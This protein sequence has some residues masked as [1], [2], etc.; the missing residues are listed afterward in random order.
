MYI[1]TYTWDKLRQY[2]EQGVQP[3]QPFTETPNNCFPTNLIPRPAS[4]NLI[5]EILF[6]ENRSLGSP[7]ATAMGGKVSNTLHLQNVPNRPYMKNLRNLRIVAAPP[8]SKKKCTA[9]GE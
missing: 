3:C 2:P 1:Y 7:L 6:L 5:P 9:V 8:P 4:P